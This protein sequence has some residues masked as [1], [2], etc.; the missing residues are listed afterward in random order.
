MLMQL[1][2][3]R[4]VCTTSAFIHSSILQFR[5]AMFE[6]V[7][8]SR[9]LSIARRR[10]LDVLPRGSRVSR[11]FRSR[12]AWDEAAYQLYRVR[13]LAVARVVEGRAGCWFGSSE[14]AGRCR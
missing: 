12:Q 4:N 6:A 8:G 2:Q 5:P 3:R 7:A 14:G 9:S 11:H 13:A 1:E 10:A